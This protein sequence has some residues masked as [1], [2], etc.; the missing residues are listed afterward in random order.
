MSESIK[1]K[2]IRGVAWSAVEKFARQGLMVFFSILIARQLSPAD[3]GLVAMLTIFLVVAQIFVDSGFVE[4][5]IQKRDRTEVDFSTTFW[6]NIGV[7]AAIYGV[8]FLLSPLIAGFYGEPLLEELTVWMGLIFVINSFRTVQQAKL[9]IAMDFHRQAWIS[10]VAIS[11]SGWMPSL[12]FSRRSFRYF[13]KFGSKIL[14]TRV[15][16]TLYMNG[17]YLLVGKF[18]SPALTGL[19]SQAVQMTSLL[20]NSIDETLSR[21]AYPIECELQNDNEA[22]RHTFYRFVRLNAFIVFPLMTGLAA[23]AEPLVRLLLME[24]WLDVVP[25]IQILCFGWI[26]QPLSGLNWQILNVKHRS[27]YYMK[28]EIFK[29]IIAFT[30]LF[31]TLFMGLVVLC[32]GWVIYCIIDLYVITLYTRR[33]LPAI[34]FKNEMRVLV[35]IL[36]RALSMGGVVYLLNYAVDSDILRIALGVPLGCV[37]YTGISLLTRSEEIHYLIDMIKKRK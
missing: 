29:K 30:I 8:L 37:L 7:A 10:L 35:P 27:D 6:F 18:Y 31:S 13:F 4:A 26:W 1:N 20:P 28:S 36:L 33:L 34:T 22:L 12:V 23:L 2:A 25:L 21:V 3:Y 16:H 24:K 5:L 17:S 32:V 11:V 9:N 19:Y 14:I 15:L